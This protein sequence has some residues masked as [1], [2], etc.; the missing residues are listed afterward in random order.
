L[1]KN[2]YQR[3]PIDVSKLETLSL[4]SIDEEMVKKLEDVVDIVERMCQVDTNNIKPLI[5]FTYL[6]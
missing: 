5:H 1:S 2:L 6:G 3:T 4:I